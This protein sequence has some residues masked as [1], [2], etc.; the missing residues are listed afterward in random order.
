MER[1][2]HRDIYIKLNIDLKFAS[3]LGMVLG[4]NDG[5]VLGFGNDLEFA[6]RLGLVLG[7]EFTATWL[8]ACLKT[9]YGT[10]HQ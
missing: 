8:R 6:T 10:S 5:I 2:R 7:L 1:K 3:R 4:I 9:W